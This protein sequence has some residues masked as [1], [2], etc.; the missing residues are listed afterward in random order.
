M[1]RSAPSRIGDARAAAG[2]S[3]AHVR[4]STRIRARGRRNVSTFCNLNV[5]MIHNHM[6]VA[7]SVEPHT[8]IGAFLGVRG[9]TFLSSGDNKSKSNSYHVILSVCT[10][11]SGCHP[12]S[13]R[14]GLGVVSGV[15]MSG[16]RKRRQRIAV[17][18]GVQH[19]RE[20]HAVEAPAAIAFSRRSFARSSW[21]I[22]LVCS[23]QTHSPFDP[24]IVALAPAREEREVS[25]S[26]LFEASRLAF[27]CVP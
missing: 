7:T 9:Q 24:R 3:R 4:P 6:Q 18:A 11:C 25:P 26:I 27:A 13:E 17:E 5:L 16:H 14:P 19:L 2:G 22:D 8:D 10:G 1:G 15:G 23:A 20:A 21:T 12:P